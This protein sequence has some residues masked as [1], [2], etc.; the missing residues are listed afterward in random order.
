MELKVI[1]AAALIMCVSSV[2]FAQYEEKMQ[3]EGVV[4]GTITVN[5][6]TIEGYIR[7]MRSLLPKKLILRTT[8]Y[9]NR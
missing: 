8:R 4:R 3:E 9:K 5:G 1:I 6:E 7:K 2:A